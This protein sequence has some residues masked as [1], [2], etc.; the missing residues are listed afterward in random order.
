MTEDL[1]VLREGQDHQL[2]GRIQGAA[3]DAPVRPLG[4][5]GLSGFSVTQAESR[6]IVSRSVPHVEGIS[7]NKLVK[8]WPPSSPTEWSTKSVRDAF[9]S[10]PQLPR[11]LNPDTVKRTISDA[12]SKGVIGYATKSA[13]GQLKLE[14]FAE[15]LPESEVEISDEAFIVPAEMAQKLVEPPRLKT[16]TIRP[17]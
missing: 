17:V 13:A 12:V 1:T 8:Y 14:R 7:P 6:E 3:A 4:E 9:Y 16:L 2:V 11:I 5:V 15:S 10:S